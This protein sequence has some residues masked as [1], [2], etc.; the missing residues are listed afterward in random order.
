[1]NTFRRRRNIIVSGLPDPEI[2]SKDQSTFFE[3]CVTHLN[4]QPRVISTK[5]HGQPGRTD[6]LRR[7]LVALS[8][9][10]EAYKII[11]VARNLRKSND[12]Q[13]ASSVFIN[14]HL[15]PEES[16]QQYMKRQARREY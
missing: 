4:I 1:M 6:S 9:D 7:L 8:T 11:Q 14:P 12:P 15:S 5:R 16:K 2:A 3:L 10:D 13:I